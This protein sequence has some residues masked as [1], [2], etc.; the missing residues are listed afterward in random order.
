[1]FVLLTSPENYLGCFTLRSSSHYFE[2]GDPL[3]KMKILIVEDDDRISIPLKE[4]LQHQ[5]YVVDLAFDGSQGLEMATAGRYDII[6]LDLML[7]KLNGFS[8]CKQLRENGNSSA[9]LMLTVRNEK[10]DKVAGL[11]CGADDYLTKPF[12]LDELS[13]RI[14]ALSRRFISQR[15][16]LIPCGPLQID[17][18]SCTVSYLEKPIEVTPT[19]YRL[20]VHFALNPTATFNGEELLDK[21]WSQEFVGGKETIKTHIKTLRKKLSA[22]GVQEPVIETVYG[23]G[24]RLRH[25]A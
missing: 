23:F 4:E 13:A 19:E 10:Q 8:V 6:L 1:V 9:I 22:A 17:T 5:N 15:Q 25:N 3:S 12:D 7:P 21:L 14:R 20:L 11:N 18:V 2:Q 24:Y 16:S